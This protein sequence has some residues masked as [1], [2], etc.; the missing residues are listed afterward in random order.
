MNNYNN[1]PLLKPENKKRLLNELRQR[2]FKQ[3]RTCPRCVI[4]IAW[5]TVIL[6]TLAC[7]FV[8]LYKKKKKKISKFVL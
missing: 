4:Y 1:I 2:I 6:W 5:I 8:A 3:Q 7:S